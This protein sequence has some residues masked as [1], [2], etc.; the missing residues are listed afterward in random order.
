MNKLYLYLPYV[1]I[2]DITAYLFFHHY[3]PSNALTLLI[4][5][6]GVLIAYIYFNL[7]DSLENLGNILFHKL[8]SQ[9]KFDF[10]NNYQIP[11]VIIYRIKKNY[12]CSNEEIRI[13]QTELKQLFKTHLDDL[14]SNPTK[15][16]N[17]V[18]NSPLAY[19]IWREFSLSGA[20]YNN[21]CDRAF[22][23]HLNFDKTHTHDVNN[24]YVKLSPHLKTY[25]LT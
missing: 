18:L 17:I 25:L 5:I 4:P 14:I 1:V 23:S 24:S 15:P 9:Q 2:L 6:I 21:F 22:G 16:T 20:A 19:E 12:D 11:S 13:A 3:N 10:I 7:Q 8:F